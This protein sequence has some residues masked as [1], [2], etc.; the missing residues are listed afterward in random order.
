[1]NFE[2]GMVCPVCEVGKMK[3]ISKNLEFE[4]KDVQV[5]IPNRKVFE[6]MI[7]KESFTDPK[8]ERELEKILTNHR[9][10]VDGL[11][12]DYEIRKIREQYN[13][14]QV[15]FAKALRVGEK[16]FARYENGHSMQS[17]AM[18]NLLRVLR[19]YPYTISA[20]HKEWHNWEKHKIIEL[21]AYHI[22]K[23]RK[24]V[25]IED[26]VECRI[27]QEGSTNAIAL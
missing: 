5:V 15:G 13:M 9:R 19:D 16:N 11:L 17:C 10:S 22:K 7:C 8:D 23:K 4:Y 21:T 14:T 3:T 25:E 12:P 2:E 24:K 18:D 26:P 27:E 6:C 1:M 20:F